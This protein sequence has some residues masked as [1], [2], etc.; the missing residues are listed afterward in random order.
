MIL[1]YLL[2]VVFVYIPLVLLLCL[3]DFSDAW[4]V[5]QFSI[6]VWA[7]EVMRI[8]NLNIWILIFSPF[9]FTLWKVKTEI[10]IYLH[11]I[12]FSYSYLTPEDAVF[13]DSSLMYTAFFDLSSLSGYWLSFWTQPDKCIK[14]YALS[15]QWLHFPCNSVIKNPPA[16]GGN[17]SSVPESGRYPGE[18]NGNTLQYS[19]LGNPM[20]KGIW[21]A[22]VHVVA[23]SWT[24]LSGSA[25]TINVWSS[26]YFL[27]SDFCRYFCKNYIWL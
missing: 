9:F 13:R 20:D 25:P 7:I 18:R 3:G 1:V 16:N 8:L 21:W 6:M 2:L 17:L 24:K 19:C 27:N 22:T 26:I 23:K 11:Y 10:D 15:Y 14:K 12:L 5:L 4:V